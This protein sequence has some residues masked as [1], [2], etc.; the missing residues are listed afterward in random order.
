MR[1]PTPA[2]VVSAYRRAV[3]TL[4]AA[5][6]LGGVGVAS[7]AAV[8]GILA[9]EVSNSTSLAGITQTMSVVGAAALA[10]PLARLAASRGR[11]VALALGYGVGTAGAG[12]CVLAASWRSLPVL[13]V[14]MLAFGGG[15][16]AGLQ[17]RYAATDA[18]PAHARAKAVSLV[19]WATTVGAVAGP[20]LA[21]PGAA[22]ARVLGQPDL[23]GAYVFSLLAFAAA[24]AV[25]LVFLRPD[26]LLAVRADRGDGV[27]GLAASAGAATGLP[28]RGSG[29]RTALRGVQGPSAVLAL[30]TLATAHAVMVA[31]MVMTPVHLH[32]HGAT[33]RV[34]GF[35]ISGHIAGMY[36]ASPLFGLF[37]DRFG[38]RAGIALGLAI[39]AVC[40]VIAGTAPAEAHVRLGAALVLLGLGWS[41]CMVSGSALL[42][43]AVADDVRTSVQGLSDL[44]MG[45]VAAAAGAVSGPLLA[46]WGYGALSVVAA[47]LLVPVVVLLVR[48]IPA[49]G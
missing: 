21:G 10:M 35:V 37:A 1:A 24:M 26:P 38:Y 30:A 17:A 9:Q 32:D 4:S 11:R 19:M 7:G 2:L 45:A 23:A 12:L 18:A 3:P 5:Q 22:L 43:E 8:G 33:L 29:L 6:V 25:L 16:A 36:A 28:A 47:M 39:L 40:L 48:A 14:G 20:N 41:A 44:I 46:L 13:L 34:V 42:G 49:R 15:T 31:V 27:A